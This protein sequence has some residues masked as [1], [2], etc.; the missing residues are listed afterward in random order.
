MG[1]LICI[2]LGFLLGRYGDMLLDGI[3]QF[4]DRNF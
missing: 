4:Y 2:G 3:R 1:Y